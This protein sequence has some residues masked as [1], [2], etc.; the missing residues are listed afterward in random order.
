MANPM[1]T[2]PAEI[3]LVD[4]HTLIRVALARLIEGMGNY[5]T[6]LQASNGAQL[7]EYLE[8]N[9]LPDLVLLDV[10]MPILDGIE[11]MKIIKQK[12]PALKVLALSMEGNESPVIGMMGNGA[13]GFVLKDSEPETLKNAI[14]DALAKGYYMSGLVTDK[15]IAYLLQGGRKNKPEGLKDKLTERE[16]E[17]L[18]YSATDITYKEIAEKMKVSP[19]T[20]DGYRNNLFEKLGVTSRVGLVLK[21]I[22]YRLTEGQK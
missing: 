6:R 16:V 15:L 2:K 21:A 13:I 22:K 19:G 10:N 9:P 14:A 7:L 17:F 1:Q 20:V 5:S 18:R 4:D 12:F 3:M 11:T 8:N